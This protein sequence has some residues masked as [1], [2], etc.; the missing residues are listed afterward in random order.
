MFVSDNSSAEGTIDENVIATQRVEA[1]L[2]QIQSINFDTSV[3][4]NQN[5]KSLQS[6]DMPNLSLPIGRKNPFA[7]TSNSSASATV[8]NSTS[9]S[10]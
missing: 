2:N 6:I 5:F 8:L 3:M 4:E 9:K 10:N 7:G 1:V